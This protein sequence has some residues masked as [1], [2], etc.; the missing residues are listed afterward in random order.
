[1][2]PCLFLV[3]LVCC[4]STVGCRGISRKNDSPSPYNQVV[5]QRPQDISL[6]DL[7]REPGRLTKCWQVYIP[8]SRSGLGRSDR[9]LG[10][11]EEGIPLGG[12]AFPPTGMVVGPGPIIAVDIGGGTRLYDSEGRFLG[13]RLGSPAGFLPDGSLVAAGV[14]P[15]IVAY[16]PDGTPRWSHDPWSETT[17]RLWG[18][19]PA[20][21]YGL[22]LVVSPT[23]EVWFYMHFFLS[24]E[25]T[26]ALVVY[27]PEG[28]TLYC[29]RVPA[30]TPLLFTPQG[31]AFCSVVSVK[32]GDACREFSATGGVFTLVRTLTLPP[33]FSWIRAVG[34]DGSLLCRDPDDG[35]TLLESYT[36]YRPGAGTA[37][38]FSLPDGHHFAA[39]TPDGRF[40]TTQLLEDFF[41][42]TAWAWP[43]PQGADM[44]SGPPR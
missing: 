11:G 14:E 35:Q 3:L 12:G 13:D 44:N 36:V 24:S 18:G 26:A 8:W 7:T 4:A 32:R 5:A 19:R 17:D 9:Y 40:Y 22:P 30:T 39:Y 41:V 6:L 34:P 37:L 16:S 38:T 2:V 23:G 20:Q 29:D 42:V 28:D 15:G 21:A 10:T 27:A 1:M 31:T 43:V 33:A 25:S